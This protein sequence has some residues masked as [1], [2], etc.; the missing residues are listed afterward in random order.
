METNKRHCCYYN[1]LVAKLKI[2]TAWCIGELFP[3]SVCVC[4]YVCAYACSDVGPLYLN[5]CHMRLHS[6]TVQT[7]KR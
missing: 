7:L 6:I 2:R 1:R 4:G 3:K 5:T